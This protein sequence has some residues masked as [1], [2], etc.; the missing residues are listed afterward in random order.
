MIGRTAG[1]L[2]LLL[3][4]LHRVEQEKHPRL[5]AWVPLLALVWGLLHRG[6]TT[7][8]PILGAAAV[9]WGLRKEYRSLAL[10][11]VGALA[12]SALALFLTPGMA[13]SVTSSADVVSVT[14]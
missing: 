5:L 4:L 3:W 6:S 12:A 2:A 11:A 9:A 8:I 10:P 1:V 7:T 13:E 14:R